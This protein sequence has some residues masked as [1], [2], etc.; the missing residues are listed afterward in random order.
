[1]EA[2]WTG[3][4][5]AQP[6]STSEGQQFNEDEQGKAELNAKAAH[7]NYR[8]SGLLQPATSLATVPILNWLG[9]SGLNAREVVPLEWHNCIVCN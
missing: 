6:R 9:P 4:T 2:T 1:M 5:L 7:A 3:W 8:R